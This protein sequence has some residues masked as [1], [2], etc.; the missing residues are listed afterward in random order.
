[1]SAA[2]KEQGRVLG[3]EIKALSSSWFGTPSSLHRGWGDNQE[4]PGKA[5]LSG[6]RPHVPGAGEGG[7]TEPLCL[8]GWPSFCLYFCFFCFCLGATSSD[9]QGSFLALLREPCGMS[10]IKPRVSCVQGIFCPHCAMAQA[11]VQTIATSPSSA[12]GRSSLS[13]SEQK[14]H[15]SWST[16]FS[17]PAP[18]G[19]LCQGAL[20]GGLVTSSSFKG[21]SEASPENQM[22]MH[23]PV[24]EDTVPR[25]GAAS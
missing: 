22:E 19:S 20:K 25:T 4:G 1:M 7:R 15:R 16:A 12:Q 6:M 18:R 17:L 8:Q 11:H 5:P 24:P 9:A 2:Q 10:E 3:P 14:E 23:I 13:P 21:Y